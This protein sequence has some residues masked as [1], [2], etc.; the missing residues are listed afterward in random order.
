MYIYITDKLS[1]P[2]QALIPA[3]PT[4]ERFPSAAWGKA[5]RGHKPN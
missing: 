5:G 1:A 3:Q 2:I 4:P